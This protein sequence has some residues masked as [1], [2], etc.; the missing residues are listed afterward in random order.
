MALR[1]EDRDLP[2]LTVLALLRTGPRHTY[3][4]Q[5]FVV[6]THKD[7]VPGVPRSMY[8]AAERLRRDGL[9]EVHA[10]DRADGRPERT[11]YALTD[12]GRAALEERVRRLLATPDR[13]ADL[14]VAGLSF[15]ACLPSAADA[16][17]ALRER[18]AA[19]DDAS[20]AA[21]R[22]IAQA[23]V[24]R[25]LL[26]EAE[27]DA[28]RLAAERDWV[29]GLADDLSSGALPWPDRVPDGIPDPF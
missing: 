4:M 21:L 29:T 9:I 1:R 26:V 18:A 13:D 11:A 2:A 19:L 28:A 8:H 7:F 16:E 3:E 5:R 20:A 17:R 10:T 6:R 15:L 12:A 24:P 25:V 23:P 14:L 27:F 22:G